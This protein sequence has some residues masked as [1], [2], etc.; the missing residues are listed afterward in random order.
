MH[1][2]TGTERGYCEITCHAR[3]RGGVRNR[4]KPGGF[5][6]TGENPGNQPGFHKSKKRH[7]TPGRGMMCGGGDRNLEKPFGLPKR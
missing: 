7:T 6:E 5:T 3:M 2:S 4:E 1:P